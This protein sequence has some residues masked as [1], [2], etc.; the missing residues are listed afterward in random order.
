MADFSNWMLV[1]LFTV[2][3]AAALWSEIDPASVSTVDSLKPSEVMAAKQIL[4]SAIL[5]KEVAVNST[6]NV[7]ASIGSFG[8]SYISRT[9]LEATARRKNVFPS[10]LFDTLLPFAETNS[11]RNGTPQRTNVMVPSSMS[12]SQPNQ[13]KG[14]RPEE[15]DW[16]TFHLEIVRLSN[17]PDGLP[18]TRA[19]LIKIMLAWFQET[20][21]REPAES[22]VKNRISKIY[23]YLE[24]GKNPS[25]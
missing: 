3:Q 4:I 17:H 22:S 6:H 25:A 19:E 11:F 14:G 16:D 2:D 12:V 15:Y 24:Q 7:F 21:G 8:D 5:A 9:D 1:D 13:N 20:Y 10:F 23:N 18:G